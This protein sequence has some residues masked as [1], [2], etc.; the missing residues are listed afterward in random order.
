MTGQWRQLLVSA[1]L[2]GWAAGAAFAHEVN[3]SKPGP[4]LVTAWVPASE[5]KPL[6]NVDIALRDHDGRA[7]TLAAL[8]DRPVL[9]TF[10]Y[11]RCQNAGKCSLAV[12]QLA[13]LQRQLT[14]ARIHDKVR[15]VA[16]TFE[17]QFDSPERM[18]RFATARGLRLGEQALAVQLDSDRHP[19]LVKELE[20]PVSYNT[21]WVS[22][23]GVEAS[24]LDARGRVVRKYTTLLWDN[25]QVLHDLERVIG[26]RP[27]IR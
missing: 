16:I 20:M 26:E 21:G 24:L 4:A 1:I 19:H 8:L 13:V 18:S 23:H 25:D 11:T 2:G 22:T 5:R 12:S 9:L 7:R 10:F 15:L 17:P 3:P 27:A 14:R 6:T